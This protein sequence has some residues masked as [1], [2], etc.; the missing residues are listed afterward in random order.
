ML[1]LRQKQP[2]PLS[3]GRK[4]PVIFKNPG[5]SAENVFIN[6]NGPKDIFK[7]RIRNSELKNRKLGR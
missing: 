1:Y 4:M 3:Y 6:V 2:G 5:K 7:I